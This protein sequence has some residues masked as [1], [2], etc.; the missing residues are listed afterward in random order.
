MSEEDSVIDFP[1]DFPVKAMGLSD[2]DVA[3]FFAESVRR[4]LPH[5]QDIQAS[6]KLSSSGKYLSVTI[7]LHALNR[8]QIDA[9]YLELNG[10]EI[11]AACNFVW[12]LIPSDLPEGFRQ[13]FSSSS[14]MGCR[15]SC[16][17]C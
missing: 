16:L 6:K 1:C 2:Y 11:V 10:N 17:K 4:H 3:G 14:G 12:T 5:Q 15:A 7:V 9:V 13:P 8:E